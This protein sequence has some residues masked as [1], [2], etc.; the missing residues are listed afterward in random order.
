MERWGRRTNRGRTGRA[1]L[2]VT[3][4]AAALVL[5]PAAGQAQ[6]AMPELTRIDAA[7][8]VAQRAQGLIDMMV[9]GEGEKAVAYLKEHTAPE[10]F[11]RV[12]G[13]MQG[14][15][16]TLATG[17]FRLRDFVRAPDH[18]DYVFARLVSASGA[19]EIV[20]VRISNEAPHRILG[21]VRVQM[22]TGHG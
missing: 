4:A 18:D 13:E 9:A 16:S 6:H 8:P 5:A 17:G 12:W 19:P 10:D 22:Q 1:G 7:E 14:M 2:A 15:A 21:L 20:G 3:V 11:E